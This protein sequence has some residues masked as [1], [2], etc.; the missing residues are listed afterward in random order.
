MEG[1]YLCVEH[2][3]GAILGFIPVIQVHD[4]TFEFTDLKLLGVIHAH[5]D[6]DVSFESLDFSLLVAVSR[7]KVPDSH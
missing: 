1:L 7:L 2:I 5:D 4:C 6:H 3:D